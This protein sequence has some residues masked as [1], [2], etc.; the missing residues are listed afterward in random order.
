MGLL[1]ILQVKCDKGFKAASG[2]ESGVIIIRCS[3]SG[4][5]EN[6]EDAP[7]CIRKRAKKEKKNSNK[8]K[9]SKVKELLGRDR[10]R[11]EKMRR[12][13]RRTDVQ[14]SVQIIGLE[15]YTVGRPVIHRVLKPRIWGVP[16]ACLGSR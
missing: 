16:P 2:T 7:K 9:E 3:R 1:N 8:R 10:K 4:V 6:A 14:G 15:M 13:D 5:I 12:K 11:K